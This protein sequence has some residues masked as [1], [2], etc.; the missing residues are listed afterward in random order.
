MTK[1]I[2]EEKQGSKFIRNCFI[3][4]TGDYKVFYTK[5]IQTIYTGGNFAFNN[6]DFIKSI[7]KDFETAKKYAE[8]L[9]IKRIFNNV[10]FSEDAQLSWK[11]QHHL[12]AFNID[13][14]LSKNKKIFYGKAN[15][16]FW[17]SWKNNKEEIKLNGFWIKK[18]DFDQW[19]VFKKT[20]II[21]ELKE[22]LEQ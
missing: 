11:G 8:E 20:N 16:E 22:E 9:K 6:I 12:N 2:N 4:V 19:I 14:D 7:T 17:E 18:N 21:S 1:Q 10:F 13:F 15:K 5:Y 3:S